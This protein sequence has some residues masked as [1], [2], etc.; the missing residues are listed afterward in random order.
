MPRA[1]TPRSGDHHSKRS[2]VGHAAP[3]GGSVRGDPDLRHLGG[4]TRTSTTT[5]RP[6]SR[7]STLRCCSPIAA[8]QR[9]RRWIMPGSAMKPTWWPGFLPFSPAV[10]HPAVPGQLPPDL[11]L[12]PEVLLPLLL[13]ATAGVRG[14]RLAARQVSR[15]DRPPHLPEPA[16]LHALHSAG[17]PADPLL[18]R[19]PGPLQGR[20]VRRRRRHADA[21]RSTR[22]SSPATPSA[23][24][25]GA[26]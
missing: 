24:T 12:L 21:L 16:P 6:I 23:V 5:R 2:L 8:R 19:V 18:R 10:P 15:R 3:P 20:T 7:R 13:H 26:T 1:A 4:A 11:L 25:P 14:R 9:R 22:R 17:V